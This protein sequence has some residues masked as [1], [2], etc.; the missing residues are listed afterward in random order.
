MLQFD[1]SQATNKNAVYLDT[2]NTASGY[3]NQLKVVY[4]QSYDRSS[5]SFDITSISSPTAYTNWLLLQNSGSDVPTPSG[6]YDV[7]IYTATGS[8]EAITWGNY[9][10]TWTAAS[11]TWINLTGSGILA[12]VDLIYSDRAYISGSNESSITTYVSS[13][14]NGTYITYNG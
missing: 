12:L 10:P 13:N 3:Y 2:V 8:V 14:E 6:Q 7:E 9:S 1:K 5:G 4:S 11:S